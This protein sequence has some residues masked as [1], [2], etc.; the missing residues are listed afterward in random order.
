MD[1]EKQSS[2][3]DDGGDSGKKMTNINPK[4]ELILKYWSL[5]DTYP[6]QPLFKIIVKITTM[7]MID[8]SNNKITLII[9][10]SFYP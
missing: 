10:Y 4:W 6:Q 5:L 2:F 3:Q 9:L 8:N 1:I 7:Q